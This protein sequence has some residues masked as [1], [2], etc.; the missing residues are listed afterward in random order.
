MKFQVPSSSISFLWWGFF[1]FFYLT[2][3]LSLV[4]CEVHKTNFSFFSPL[5]ITNHY[6]YSCSYLYMWC[7][8]ND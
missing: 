4:S 6:S 8:L 5:L 7:L 3:F 1:F 2:D